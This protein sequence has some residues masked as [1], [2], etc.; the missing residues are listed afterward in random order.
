MLE[1]TM[2][3]LSGELQDD[4]TTLYVLFMCVIANN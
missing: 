3:D 2:R 4:F 1:D